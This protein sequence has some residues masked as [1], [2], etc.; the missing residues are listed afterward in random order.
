MNSTL[1]PDQIFPRLKIDR[2][3][4]LN[5][6]DQGR[7]MSEKPIVPGLPDSLLHLHMIEDIGLT[8][9]AR[10]EEGY[11]FVREFDR[12]DQPERDDQWFAYHAFRNLMQE[13]GSTAILELR[14]NGIYQVVAG[15]L[16]EASLLLLA[17][18]WVELLPEY[19]ENLYA[20]I[21]AHNELYIASSYGY[22]GILNLQKIIRN[23][24]QDEEYLE[25]LSK[26]I[27]QRINGEWKIVATAF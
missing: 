24:F 19:G 11:R 18:F 22:L 23:V 4:A 2:S 26:C 14:E 21:P 8:F 15:G 5:A 27:Y 12:E 3:H 13:I 1:S 9:I 17:N 25:P 16:H 10:T 6:P 7:Q 20:A